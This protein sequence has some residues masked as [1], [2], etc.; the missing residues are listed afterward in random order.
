M[1]LRGK[2]GGGEAEQTPSPG[3]FPVN[4]EGGWRQIAIRPYMIW[5]WALNLDW[6]G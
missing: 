5:E 6:L 2:A 1:I 3:P 4:G